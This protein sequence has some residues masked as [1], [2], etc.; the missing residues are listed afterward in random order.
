MARA[1][2]VGS[3]GLFG[4]PV[5]GEW[6]KQLTMAGGTRALRALSVVMTAVVARGFLT[7]SHG[8]HFVARAAAGS[9]HDAAVSRTG[10]RRSPVSTRTA[11]VG[12]IRMVS[13]VQH[14]ACFTSAWFQNS[15]NQPS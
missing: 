15:V 14:R 4:V 11:P 6:R 12:N 9:K 13:V 5:S 3:V 7:P 2:G 8:Q 10:C 1:A